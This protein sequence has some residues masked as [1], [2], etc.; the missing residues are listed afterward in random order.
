LTRNEYIIE[1][2]SNRELIKNFESC[3]GNQ[4]QALP[5]SLFTNPS[6]PFDKNWRTLNDVEIKAPQ[7]QKQKYGWEI[8]CMN[9]STMKPSPTWTTYIILHKTT[10]A[11]CG[12]FNHKFFHWSFSCI[13]RTIERERC[14]LW[15]TPE[16]NR[17]KSQVRN[18][19][20]VVFWY[21]QESRRTYMILR[22]PISIT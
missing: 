10:R 8:V 15:S 13:D 1:S 7:W 12:L 19:S 21:V 3:V 6:L 17:K 9:N 22:K 20:K 5:S 4:A 14:C 18:N 16:L 11:D 2:Y